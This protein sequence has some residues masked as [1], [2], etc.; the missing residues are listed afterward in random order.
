[1]QGDNIAGEAPLVGADNVE[2][3]LVEEGA[4]DDVEDSLV[5]EGSCGEPGLVGAGME[6]EDGWGL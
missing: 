2:D 6:I 3:S 5:G 4:A 1:M